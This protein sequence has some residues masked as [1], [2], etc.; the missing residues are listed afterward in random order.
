MLNQ[1][2]RRELLAFFWPESNSWQRCEI[3]ELG[4]GITL[5]VG[6]S[7]IAVALGGLPDEIPVHEQPTPAGTS[8]G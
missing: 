6:F 3:V 1:A 4:A 2:E 5:F 8:G 7:K